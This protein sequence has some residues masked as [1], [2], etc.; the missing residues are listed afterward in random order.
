MSIVTL[1]RK[2]API[3]YLSGVVGDLNLRGCG[4]RGEDNLDVTTQASKN[5]SISKKISVEN[6]IQLNLVWEHTLRI[7][8]VCEHTTTM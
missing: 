5:M 1:F 3:C 8:E 7:C 6:K 4:A 2:H